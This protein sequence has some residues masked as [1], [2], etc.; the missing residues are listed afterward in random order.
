MNKIKLLIEHK[1]IRKILF[2]IFSV[3]YKLNFNSIFYSFF[4]L[5]ISIKKY[6]KIY[7]LG[8][9]K[10]NKIVVTF[11]RQSFLKDQ[12]ELNKSK[13]INLIIIKPYVWATF[14]KVFY[15]K[16]MRGQISYHLFTDS[17]SLEIKKSAEEYVVQTLRKLQ[18]KNLVDAFLVGNVDYMEHQS[19]GAAAKILNIPFVVMLCEGYFTKF[20]HQKFINQ[21]HFMAN[22]KF[23]Y[24]KVFVPGTSAVLLAN[25]ANI[26]EKKDI[27]VTGYP[28]TDLSYSIFSKLNIENINKKNTIL[29]IAFNE[30]N[31]LADNLWTS[32]L[33]N[34][35]NNARNNEDFKFVIKTKK[36]SLTKKLLES[37]S[38]EQKDISNLSIDHNLDISKITDEV[39]LIISFTSTFLLEAMC[40]QIPLLVPIWDDGKVSYDSGATFFDLKNNGLDYIYS[41]NEFNHT[42]NNLYQSKKY[43]TYLNEIHNNLSERKKFLEPFLY[44]V[45]GKRTNYVIKNIVDLIK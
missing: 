27:V 34:F 42:L 19:W 45:D 31:Y 8:Y 37:L 21:E 29:L 26:A 35:C 38:H 44:K 1:I 2:L 23:I 6:Y 25:N 17:N 12:V 39:R 41:E 13:A 10:K 15:P 14:T 24:D 30:P 7:I 5:Y 9:D 18:K 33:N 22:T 43:Q 32:V 11:C 3:S 40:S 20:W 28:R 4:Y 36:E 16:Y